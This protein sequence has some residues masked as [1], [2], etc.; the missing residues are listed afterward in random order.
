MGRVNEES[1]FSYILHEDCNID[2]NVYE[3]QQTIIYNLTRN[4]S[5]RIPLCI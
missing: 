2:K 5:N 4:S 3:N 1:K